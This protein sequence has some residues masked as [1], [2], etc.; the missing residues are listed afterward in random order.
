MVEQIALDP[1]AI[2]EGYY[3]WRKRIVPAMPDRSAA[4]QHLN[5]HLGQTS[6]LALYLA[7]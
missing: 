3:Q 4:S 7:T 5:P 1:L 2:P 6:N